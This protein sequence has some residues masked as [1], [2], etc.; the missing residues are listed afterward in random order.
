MGVVSLVADSLLGFGL[1]LRVLMAVVSLV[2]I[3][4]LGMLVVATKNHEQKYIV[5]HTVQKY[6][7]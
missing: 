1:A 6:C 7:V 2:A 3:T 4:L 5:N